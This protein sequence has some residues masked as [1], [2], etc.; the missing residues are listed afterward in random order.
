MIELFK[1]YGVFGIIDILDYFSET[2]KKIDFFGVADCFIPV[3]MHIKAVR[4]RGYNQALLIAKKLSKITRIPVCFDCVVKVKQTRSQVGLSYSERK[5]N[6]KG[7]FRIFKLK[8]GVKRAV[9]V[10]DVF[11]T[12]S[13]INEI[14][15]LLNRHSVES[16]FFTL[17]STP[18]ID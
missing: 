14:A 4:K 12:G 15:S 5:K 17:A 18:Q 8:S 16:Y 10:D 1:F 3:P 11:T 7:A 6:L 9:V 13:T 2:L